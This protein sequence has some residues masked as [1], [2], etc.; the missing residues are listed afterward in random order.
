M[1]RHGRYG[2]IG[3][4]GYWLGCF[5]MLAI[6]VVFRL[7]DRGAGELGFAIV[8]NFVLSFVL[9]VSRLRNIGMS[10]WWALL[11]LVPC[12]GIFVG[13]PCAICPEGYQDTKKLDTAGRVLAGIFIAF[14]VI[15]VIIAIVAVSARG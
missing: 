5:A 13:V 8:I 7:A 4:L 11:L 14:L 6:Y 1:N 2:G 3:R 15:G 9:V 10:S 12:A